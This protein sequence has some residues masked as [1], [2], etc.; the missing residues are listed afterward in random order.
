MSL[1]FPEP[2]MISKRSST[3]KMSQRKVAQFLD[4]QQQFQAQT[5][6]KL[7]DMSLEAPFKEKPFGEKLS[8]YQ[9]R[10]FEGN[11]RMKISGMS[12]Q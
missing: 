11:T 4:R 8:K 12:Y 9:L 5:Q 2:D 6:Q 3:S 7:N 1:D 10:D